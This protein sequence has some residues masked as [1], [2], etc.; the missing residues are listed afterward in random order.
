MAFHR[1]VDKVD[2]LLLVAHIADVMGGAGRLLSDLAAGGVRMA[3]ST[4]D[5]SSS[6]IRVNS[7]SG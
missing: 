2:D 3:S 5:R 6:D 7:V 1:G 4:V